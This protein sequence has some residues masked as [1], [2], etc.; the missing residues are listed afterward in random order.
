MK[1]DIERAQSI[2]ECGAFQEALGNTA[3]PDEDVRGELLNRGYSSVKIALELAEAAGRELTDEALASIACAAAGWAEP[4][5]SALHTR[6]TMVSWLGP[7]VSSVRLPWDPKRGKGKAKAV[8]TEPAEPEAPAVPEIT[9]ERGAE[10]TQMQGTAALMDQAIMDSADVF[11]ALGRI[12]ASAFFARIGN[13]SAA[14]FAQQVR[15]GK[16]YKGLPYNDQDGKRKYISDF[17]E[18]CE[19]FLGK[20]GRYVR[21]LVSN[22]HTLGSDLYE[23]AESVGFRAKDY[24]ALKAL[25]AAEQEVIKQALASESKEQVLDILQDFAAARAA[26]REAAK[27]ESDELK[28]DKDALDKLLKDKSEKLDG[29]TVK[30]EKLRS[31]PENKRQK[32][33]LEQEEQAAMKLAEAVI[34]VQ[35]AVNEFCRQLADIKGAEVSIYTQQHA[36]ATASWLCQQIQYALQE[37]GIQ[38]DMAEIVLPTW[39]RETA[40]ASPVAEAQA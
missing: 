16:K 22:L 33:R 26:E 30:L 28:A 14:Q 10:L 35:A 25:P 34:G 3:G 36:D 8:Q 23:A 9:E 4:G 40:K 11:K 15:Q 29:L 7:D 6:H 38:A 21:D 19:V 27:K 13:I 18:F 39:M 12:E 32:L 31:L 24:A 17:D 20:T 5:E 2:L 1:V 37:N